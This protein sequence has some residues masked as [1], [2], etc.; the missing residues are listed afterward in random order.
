MYLRLFIPQR[1][2]HRNRQRPPCEMN[3]RPLTAVRRN[4]PEGI[5]GTWCLGCCGLGP[6]QTSEWCQESSQ[7]LALLTLGFLP[8]ERRLCPLRTRIS[9]PRA[10]LTP[11]HT[12]RFLA[13]SWSS[14]PT[15]GGLLG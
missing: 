12:C 1:K 4:G 6:W 3:S 10:G 7:K 13:R 5:S 8:P 11:N 14:V 9:L 2:G 15:P